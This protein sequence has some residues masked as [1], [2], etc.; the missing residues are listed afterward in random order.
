MSKNSGN[1]S[2]KPPGASSGAS[3]NNAGGVKSKYAIVKE[4]RGSRPK[5]QHSYGLGSMGPAG[6]FASG[7]HIA[8]CWVKVDPEGIEEGNRIL[9]AMQEADREELEASGK[10]SK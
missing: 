5:F 1:P 7:L 10:S 3:S 9:E 2:S 8:H 4:G 6:P